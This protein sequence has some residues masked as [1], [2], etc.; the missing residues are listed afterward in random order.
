VP[1]LPWDFTVIGTPISVNARSRSAISQWKQIVAT[2]ARAIWPA[3][4]APLTDGLQIH[5]TCYHDS[6][7]PL[8]VD[9]MIKPIQDA[10]KGI[11]YVDDRQLTDTAGHLRD[12]NERFE[13][14][15]MTPEQARGFVSGQPF[16]HIR[17]ELSPSISRLP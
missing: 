16:V 3:G 17:I 8:D 13:V 15:G 11:V 2:E 6:A 12:V 4:E 14:R 9:N 10:L 7:P 5:I 1:Q